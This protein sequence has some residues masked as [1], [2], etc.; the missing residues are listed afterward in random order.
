MTTAFLNNAIGKLYNIYDKEKLNKYIS[1]KNIS[2][3]DLNLMK[4]VIDRAKIKFSKEDISILEKELE[5]EC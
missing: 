2:K 4:K 5:D 1:M 3:S